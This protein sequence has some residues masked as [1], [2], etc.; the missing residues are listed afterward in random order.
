MKTPMDPTD[1]R[2]FLKLIGTPALAAAMPL[3]FSR[4]LAIPAHNRTGSIADVEHIIFL[5]QENRSFDYY[6]GTMR[7]AGAVFPS[8]RATA[9]MRPDPSPLNRTS[10]WSRSGPLGRAARRITTCLFTVPTALSRIQ[11]RHRRPATGK[12][13]RPRRLRRRAHRHHARDLESCVTDR[14]N[15]DRQPVHVAEH[16]APARARRFRLKELAAVALGRL[17]RPGDHRRRRR[18]LPVS[19]G[20]SS[21]ER[22]RQHHRS[23]DGRSSVGD[24]TP[25]PAAAAARATAAA[26]IITRRNADTNDSSM[27]PRTPAR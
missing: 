19:A 18:E 26:A 3:S 13:R 21:R 11:G 17:V 1:R 9:P 22:R 27:V 23:V 5:M 24:A 10:D 25:A 16:D 12:P 20:G 7:E 15:R 4:A 6:F 8:V 14:S 2:T